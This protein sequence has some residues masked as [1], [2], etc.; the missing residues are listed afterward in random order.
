MLVLV[1]FLLFVFKKNLN[2]FFILL[3]L[4]YDLSNIHC[5]LAKLYKRRHVNEER[6]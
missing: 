5:N 4:V 6:A 2:F 3:S 1:S